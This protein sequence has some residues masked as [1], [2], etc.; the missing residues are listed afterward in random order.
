MLWKARQA[1]SFL[2]FT[3]LDTYF[4]PDNFVKISI[5]ISNHYPYHSVIF[6]TDGD[7]SPSV[8][9]KIGGDDG[10]KFYFRPIQNSEDYD[11]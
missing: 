11:V 9:K 8:T 1:V 5:D 6:Q 7:T 4:F 2:F 3:T 10:D